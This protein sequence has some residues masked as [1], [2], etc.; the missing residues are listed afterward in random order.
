M[1]IKKEKLEFREKVM[2]CIRFNLWIRSKRLDT[3]YYATTVLSAMQWKLTERFGKTLGF[4]NMDDYEEALNF[5]REEVPKFIREAWG[6]NGRVNKVYD[7][8]WEEP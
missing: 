6:R 3:N 2:N 1:D 5:L 8:S 4:L 7:S